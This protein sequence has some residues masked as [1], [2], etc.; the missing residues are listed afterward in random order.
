[1]FTK[2]GKPIAVSGREKKKTQKFFGHNEEEVFEKMPFVKQ[3]IEKMNR[4][5]ID[6]HDTQTVE[7]AQTGAR[8]KDGILNAVC[9]YYCCLIT[10]RQKMNV[11]I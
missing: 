3:W 11:L 1:M 6:R 5:R 7:E 9:N 2:T 10:Y 4:D 8:A